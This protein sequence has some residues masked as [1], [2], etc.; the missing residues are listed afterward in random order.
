MTDA[1]E[2]VE[3]RAPRGARVLEIDWADGHT[4][5]YSHEVLR[6][7][8]PCAHCQG[9]DGP[10]CFVEGG[11]VELEDIQTVGNYAVRLVWGDGH[12]TGI[13]S[14]RYLRE[15]CT[16]SSCSDGDARK[17]SFSRQ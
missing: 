15:L 10:I 1:T 11:D 4:G 14:F 5:T 2:P 16:C 8:C 13:Y 17:R 12:Q 6:G 7:F 3:L 9:H